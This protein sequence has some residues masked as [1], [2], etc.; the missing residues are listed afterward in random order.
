MRL[1]KFKQDGD[2]AIQEYERK[3]IRGLAQKVYQ[4]GMDGTAYYTLRRG[5]ENQPDEPKT[6]GKRQKPIDHIRKA[7]GLFLAACREPVYGGTTL[8]RHF[9]VS[10]EHKTMSAPKGRGEIPP[11]YDAIVALYELDLVVKVLGVHAYFAL[12]GKPAQS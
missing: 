9:P 1:I 7:A 6:A 5:A 2:E 11:F 3:E 12:S 10:F 8:F 4:P